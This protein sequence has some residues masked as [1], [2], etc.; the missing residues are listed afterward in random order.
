MCVVNRKTLF[1]NIFLVLGA[2]LFAA[3]LSEI[4]LRMILPTPV[5]WKYPQ[6]SYLFD[7]ESG[8]RLKPNQQSFTHDK[9]VTTNS[10][11]IRDSDYSREPARQV[12]RIIALGDSQTFGN[13]LAIE[14][15]WPKQ[16]ERKLNGQAGAGRYEVLN[17]GLPGSDTWQH[18]I[19]LQRLLSTYNPRIVV[20]AFY[21]NDIVSRPASIRNMQGDEIGSV[22]WRLVYL[23]KQSAFLLTM[24]NAYDAVMQSL[25][26]RG[27]FLL[28]NAVLAGES[29][30]E[31]ERRWGQVE[32]SLLNMRDVTAM[33][34][35]RFLVVSL[36]RRDQV[37]GRL[38]TEKYNERL[39]M[40]I[41]K[42]G[43]K[44]LNMLGP[45]QNAYKEHGKAL[46]IPWDGHNTSIANRVIAWKIAESIPGLMTDR[47]E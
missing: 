38:K 45:M 17:G 12:T 28:Q 2:L 42:T 1:G 14:D 23:L 25:V 47:P 13:G 27:D 19:L 5:I 30:P 34:N 10:Q 37:D 31:I 33:S 29:N 8:H 44:Y 46:F 22:G 41:N 36:P 15:T 24:R 6:E 20:L 43:V 9:L 7:P 21:V 16:L 18:E 3:I 26:P 35:V 32:R 4:L 11:G 39:S 40:V